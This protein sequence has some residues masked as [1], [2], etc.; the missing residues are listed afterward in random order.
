[1]YIPVYQNTNITKKHVVLKYC[2]CWTISRTQKFK[3]C[4]NLRGAAY[5]LMFKIFKFFRL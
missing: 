4:Y 2:I 1:M 3:M 5:T